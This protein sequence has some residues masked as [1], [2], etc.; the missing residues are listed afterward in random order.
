MGIGDTPTLRGPT[1]RS[2]CPHPAKRTYATKRCAKRALARSTRRQG[3]DQLHAYRC[4]CG[5]WHIGHKLTAPKRAA[6]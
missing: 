1:D 6:A 5:F 3:R 4:A 2:L